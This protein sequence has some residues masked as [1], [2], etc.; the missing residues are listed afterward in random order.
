VT[1][2]LTPLKPQCPESEAIRSGYIFSLIL[3][4]GERK[5]YFIM[6]KLLFFLFCSVAQSEDYWTR[7]IIVIYD[8]IIFKDEINILIKIESINKD[9]FYTAPKGNRTQI[10]LTQEE[11]A[12]YY[13]LVNDSQYLMTRIFDMRRNSELIKAY[14]YDY[15]S[16]PLISN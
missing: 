2:P 4:Q 13:I 7:N 5:I 6:K 15:E 16:Y 1:N 11:Q 8:P 14:W 9:I 3:E 12:K 10:R